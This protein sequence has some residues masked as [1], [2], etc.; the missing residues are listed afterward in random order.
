[1]PFDRSDT[2]PYLQ[3]DGP[4]AF[5]HRGGATAAPENTLKAFEDAVSLGYQYIETDVHATRDGVLVA[6]H[7]NDLSRTCGIS[8]RIN[9]MN[10]S[11]VSR[12]RVHQA[13]PI[14]LLEDIL[15]SFPNVKVNIDCKANNAVDPLIMT[16]RRTNSLSRVCIGSFSDSRLKILREALGDEA[17]MSAGPLAV[18]RLVL[19]SRSHRVVARSR[20]IQAAQVPVTQGPLTVV[21]DRFVSVCHELGLHV[22]VWT[23]DDP[24]EMNRLLDMGVD[25]VMTD[26]TRA[27][28]DVLTAR[29]QWQH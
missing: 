23:I 2:H 7:D 13:E 20:S 28:K 5:A 8:G 10:W 25:G 26:D 17:C 21:N 11:D 3:H 12:A 9:E 27:L 6:F 14:P 18:S 22:H 24:A 15:G 1:M 29:G 19:A 4:I 16:L